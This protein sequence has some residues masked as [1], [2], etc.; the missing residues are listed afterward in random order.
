M[1]SLSRGLLM[2]CL[3]ACASEE[4]LGRAVFDV[5]G[6]EQG[7]SQATV[8]CIL[9]D[10]R[11]Y[12]WFGTDDGLNRYDGTRFVQYRS[13]PA[14]AASLWNNGVWSLAEDL[15]GNIWIG[16]QRGGLDRYERA[17]GVFRPMLPDSVRKEISGDAVVCIHVDDANRVWA[18]T[19]KS[20]LLA[21]DPENLTT[22]RF[23]AARDGL[24]SDRIRS[25]ARDG[26]GRLLVGTS[27]GG[28]F[29]FVCDSFTI[30]TLHEAD[31]PS[32][33]LGNVQSIVVVKDTIWI[34]TLNAGVKRMVRSHTNPEIVENVWSIAELDGKATR[35]I[36]L[37]RKGRLWIATASEGL[38]EYLIDSAALVWHR[39]SRSDLSSLPEDNLLCL[40]I[41]K[42]DDLWLGTWSS[43][44]ARL[45]LRETPFQ[46]YEIGGTDSAQQDQRFAVLALAEAAGGE[47]LAGTVGHG[48][49]RLADVNSAERIELLPA[50]LR[51]ATI[52]GLRYFTNDSA[53]I[54]T[55]QSGV[56]LYDARAKTLVSLLLPAPLDTL[57]IASVLAM[58]YD[59]KKRWWLGTVNQGLICWDSEADTARLYRRTG[60]ESQ[61]ISDD[62]VYALDE[63]SQ[64]NV[65]VG[66]L[67]GL[68]CLA[69]SGQFFKSFRHDRN[70]VNTLPNNEIR[71]IDEGPDGTLWVGTSNGLCA[72]SKE[73]AHITRFTESA[74]LANGV[75]YG[76]LVDERGNAWVSTNRGISVV[77]RNS[78]AIENYF[79]WD[80]L[81]N[82]EFN[83]GAC[84]RLKS[85]ELVFGG[86]QAVVRFRPKDVNARKVPVVVTAVRD[87][88]T[89]E[90][91]AREPDTGTELVLPHARR[92]LVIDYA[93]IEFYGGVQRGYEYSLSGVTEQWVRNV[94]ENS[95]VFTNLAPGRYRFAVKRD[96]AADGVTTALDIT[97]RAPWWLRTEALLFWAASGVA[98]MAFAFTFVQRRE[99][100]RA[101]AKREKELQVALNR[102]YLLDLLTI[103]GHSQTSKERLDGMLR[104]CR[105][106]EDP[107]DVGALERLR[108]EAAEFMAHAGDKLDDILERVSA[109]DVPATIAARFT[110]RTQQL[111]ESAQRAAQESA[112][113]ELSALAPRLQ[114]EIDEF[115]RSL[116]QLVGHLAQ[117][118]VTDIGEAIERVL[119]SK[120][121]ELDAA[122]VTCSVDCP[123]KLVCF[124]DAK[125]FGTMLDY[126]IANSIEAMSGSMQREV[127]LLVIKT[128]PKIELLLQDTG[129]GISKEAHGMVFKR[130]FSSKTN[131]VGG[132]GLYNARKTVHRYQGLIN[133]QDSEPGRGTT[134]RLTLQPAGE[135][136]E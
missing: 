19:T 11:G 51:A 109:A 115:Q 7:L 108:L 15:D 39:Q 31:H 79:T 135:Q 125:E 37:D 40:T 105:R 93:A 42:S 122:G 61:R 89:N 12:L 24:P 96:G 3:F 64:G 120:R 66:T 32:T 6:T 90:Y 75:I 1:T 121:A 80:G 104:N 74:G 35:S 133:I 67:D 129:R 22:R 57:K 47:I 113:S 111:E 106:L 131:G 59:S 62:I 27:N 136:D 25:I 13:D 107:E 71:G 124:F 18:G 58:L 134:F 97:I 21:V 14:D 28:L 88:Q 127:R 95:A 83:Q 100:K 73:R 98:A 33:A 126:L 87:Y 30:T 17:T 5:F 91:L 117:L 2:L 70:D 46:T 86:S 116:K 103:F 76:L 132:L 20:G 110:A 53:L 55:Y 78:G 8:H 118:Y 44:A 34:A 43:G 52:T 29:S 84:L 50:A 82:G 26:A 49:Q 60:A 77:R 92:H 114:I 10:A 4:S 9:Q 36:Q 101:F 41:D 48:V 56:H 72:V 63:D 69:P 119:A 23:T 54:A 45:R 81:P 65:W 16:T 130:N 38:A 112:R 68:D 123:A 128:A 85:G 94:P 102:H 99:R